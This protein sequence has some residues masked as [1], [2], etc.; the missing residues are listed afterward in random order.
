MLSSDSILSLGVVMKHI[1]VLTIV[2]L[3]ILSQQLMASEKEIIP[4]LFESN[5]VNYLS[6]DVILNSVNGLDQAVMDVIPINLYLDAFNLQNER[7]ESSSFATGQ[8]VKL[9]LPADIGEVILDVKTLEQDGK[10]ELL[11]YTG[12]IKGHRNSSFVITSDGNRM[13][14]QIV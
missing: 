3:F 4:T 1:V 5:H 14:G 12:I 10:E 2:F 6:N 9:T 13:M 7:I 8:R 11:T